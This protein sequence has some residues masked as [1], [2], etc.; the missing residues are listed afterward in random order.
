[1]PMYLVCKEVY[2][3]TGIVYLAIFNNEEDA[4]NYV[5]QHKGLDLY[6][7]KCVNGEEL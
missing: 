2:Y 7:K 6:I 3:G 4:K 1:M 5:N